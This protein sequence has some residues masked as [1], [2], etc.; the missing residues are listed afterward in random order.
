MNPFVPD[1]Y[2]KNTYCL[3]LGFSFL[4]LDFHVKVKHRQPN[5]YKEERSGS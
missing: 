4:Q 1:L 2:P 3:Y 5:T